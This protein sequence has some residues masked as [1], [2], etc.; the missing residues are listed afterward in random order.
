[1]CVR[2]C[3]CVCVCVWVWVSV[4]V[5][6]WVWECECQY[7]CESV[8][9]TVNLSLW[10]QCSL[11]CVSLRCIY[12]LIYM[13]VHISPPNQTEPTKAPAFSSLSVNF[14]SSRSAAFSHTSN[15]I[16]VP[17]VHCIY[18]TPITSK[19]HLFSLPSV[20]LIT[21]LCTLI[22]RYLYIWSFGPALS[23]VA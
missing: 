4:W 10:C 12:V 1:M 7:Q 9:V 3:V 14:C 6:V 13:I 21:R 22:F 23:L 5:W 19:S 15:G 2:V 17:F 11:V 18:H 16:S 8:P 20:L